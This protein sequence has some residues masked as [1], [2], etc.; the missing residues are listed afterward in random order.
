MVVTALF[1]VL[2][3]GSNLRNVGVARVPIASVQGPSTIL[4]C[5]RNGIEEKFS[6]NRTN[7]SSPQMPRLTVFRV[8][9]L[10]KCWAHA[11]IDRFPVLAEAVAHT[12]QP[13]EIWF[14]KTGFELY[15]WNKKLV[16]PRT[17]KYRKAWGALIDTLGASNVIFEHLLSEPELQRLNRRPNQVVVDICARPGYALWDS[18]EVYAERRCLKSRI[19]Y[20]IRARPLLT[21]IST[22][23]NALHIENS[24]NNSIHNGLLIIDRLSPERKFPNASLAELSN[25]CHFLMGYYGVPFLG[26]HYLENLSLRQQIILIRKSSVVVMRHGAGEAT[27]L[28]ARKNTIL[29]EVNNP[30]E[31]SQNKHKYYSVVSQV[32]NTTHISGVDSD[33]AECRLFAIYKSMHRQHEVDQTKIN[34]MKFQANNSTCFQNFHLKSYPTGMFANAL[35]LFRRMKAA[36]V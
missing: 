12:H 16:D 35:T 11:L 17:R 2:C 34:L 36:L 28:F 20:S 7:G 33:A 18:C 9:G 5:S 30:E 32:A 25:V 27:M 26:V 15:P 22:V 10:H 14:I 24:Q 23:L 4:F 21:T 19:D 13:F 3:L 31:I 1:T 8:S 29:L 6:S